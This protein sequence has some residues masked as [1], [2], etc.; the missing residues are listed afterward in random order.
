MDW[1]AFVLQHGW[2][3]KAHHLAHVVGRPATDV[4]VVR[5]SRA[6]TRRNVAL[7]FVEL[8]TAWHG[9]PPADEEWPVP[10][11]TRAGSYEWQA[12]ELLL[13]ASLVGQMG[14]GDIAAALTVR[15]R[16]V[17]GDPHASR[18]KS[19]IQSRASL[20]GLQL[21]ADLIGG[22]T[23]A[24]AGR[25]IGSL[26]LVN[27]AVAKK[28]LRVVRIG[29][30]W[31]IPHDAWAEWK[32]K[33]V[34]PPAGYIRLSELKVPL[35]I[36]SDKLSEWARAG[37]IESAVRC[38]PYGT[39]GKSTQFGTWFVSPGVATKLIA[40]RHAGR[41]MPWHGKPFADNAR[42]T[43][44]LWLERKH[45][46]HC[47]TCRDIWGDLGAP[48]SFETY[49]AQY[50][51]LAHGAKR[52]LTMVWQP[53]LTVAEVAE[54]SLRSEA[55]VRRAID[56]GML[57]VRKEGRRVYVSRT[58]ATRWITRKC[59]TGTKISSWTAIDIASANYG[60]TVEELR[61]FIADGVLQSRT[62]TLG[63]E[64]GIVYVGRQQ[65]AQLREEIG[66]T[67][68]DAAKRAGVSVARFRI[69][70][71]G[72][73]WRKAERIPLA[74]VQAVI[75]RLKS[76]SGYDI[77]EAAEQLGKT[78]QWVEDRVADGTIR[79]NVAKW[80]GRRRYVSEPMMARLREAALTSPTATGLSDAWLHL[81][82]AVELAG[83][84]AGTIMKWADEGTLERRESPTGW[85]YHCEAVRARARK[86]WPTCRFHRAVP[87][88]WLVAEGG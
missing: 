87:P 46:V 15:L 30:F 76:R 49:Q 71:A 1:K 55:H 9:R 39:R 57:R 12:P 62:G 4:E 53:G 61:Q 24:A 66:F 34:F 16:A 33:R 88:A 70:L 68:E 69:V 47:E 8:F 72:V 56:A 13:L 26:A 2:G 41:P 79:V 48:T 18:T 43:Y 52:H 23:T 21:R 38:N 54:Q 50:P 45:P 37:Y 10:A 77:A 75:K 35:G 14:V 36:V 65:C 5:Q 11:I 28:Q 7:N 25:E 60:F 73:Q 44:A 58:D 51:P 3:A 82:E 20:I 32:S 63:A 78:T 59:P 22:I 17:T 67:E 6:L 42:V 27:Q 85:R 74:T 64:R 80:D 86:Y 31:L 19:A 84:T 83:V 81:G 29:R 40:D